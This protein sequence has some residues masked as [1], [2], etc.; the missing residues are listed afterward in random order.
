MFGV[1]KIKYILNIII[2]QEWHYIDHS[3]D[4]YNFNKYINAVLFIKNPD[5]FFFFFFFYNYKKCFWASN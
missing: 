5:F 4:I 3:N 2:Q 1:S